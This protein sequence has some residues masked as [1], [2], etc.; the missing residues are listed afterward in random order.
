MKRGS[1]QRPNI[2]MMT[3][4]NGNIFRVTG[5]LCGEFTGPRWIPCTKA[6]DAELYVFFD[7]RLNKRLS[8]QWWG[9]WF[10]TL[11]HPLWRHR[12]DFGKAACVTV[13]LGATITCGSMKLQKL[14]IT[15]QWRGNN[16]T[17]HI[18]LSHYQHNHADVHFSHTAPNTNHLKQYTH[19]FGVVMHRPVLQISFLLSSCWLEQ[20]YGCLQCRY[21]NPERYGKPRSTENCFFN[22]N[23]LNRIKLCTRLIIWDMI[24]CCTKWFVTFSSLWRCSI[25]VCSTSCMLHSQVL[26]HA[27]D[28]FVNWLSQ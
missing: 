18:L 1:L 9:W 14:H 28:Q 2:H 20:T 3:S 27:M 12:I 16:G 22:Q 23:K 13:T 19:G 25:F 8:K 21:S 15:R 24:K 6:S 5:H 10:E 4:S 17:W 26:C 7:L 11:S